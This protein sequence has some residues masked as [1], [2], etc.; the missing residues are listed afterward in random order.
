ML[1]TLYYFTGT[2]NS[3]FIAKTL[4]EILGDTQLIPIQTYG[5]YQKLSQQTERVG[6]IYPTYFLD[7][8]E[9][10]KEF[11]EQLEIPKQS[12]V[13]LYTNY[14]ESMG[15]ALYNPFLQLSKK[16]VKDVAT[17]GVALPDN[18]IVFPSKI[19]MIPKMCE[20]A[21]T[22][23]QTHGEEIL[24]K[25][26]VK[27]PVFN[28]KNKLLS[29][30]MKPY[31]HYYLGFDSIQ[32][33]DQRCSGCGICKNV[34]SNQNITCQNDQY[35]AGKDCLMCFAC[36]HYCPNQAVSFKRMKE[37]PSYQYTNSDI[38]LKEIM[39]SRL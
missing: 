4:A 33:N 37:S 14:G 31:C 17:Y 8:P 13:F 18:S 23:L 7:A 6:I 35:K 39:D 30:F 9:N 10:V 3:L 28:F 11:I 5:T 36:I 29:Q 15:N 24:R 38:K 16:G 22:I 25:A 26:K 21:K 27:D 1:T 20:D 19:E 32:I 2:G 12:Y 34:C